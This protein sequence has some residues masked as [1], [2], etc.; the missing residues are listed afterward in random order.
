[1]RN[2]VTRRFTPHRRLR[3]HWVR[4]EDALALLIGPEAAKSMNA[5]YKWALA[6]FV[7]VVLPTPLVLIVQPGSSKAGLSLIVGLF[8]L[9]CFCFVQGFRLGSQGTR[10]AEKYVGQQLGRP[11]QFGFGKLSV[12]WWRRR[13][14]CERRTS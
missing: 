10:L 5:Y 12:S 1:M 13:I 4:R 2:P 8:V 9:A 7:C 14:E 6:A 3:D 11:V